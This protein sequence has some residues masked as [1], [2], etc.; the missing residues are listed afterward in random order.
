M[1]RGA[2]A[3]RSLSTKTMAAPP[4]MA[5]ETPATPAYGDTEEVSEKVSIFIPPEA[6]GGKKYEIGDTVTLTVK[7]IDQETGEIEAAT[8]DV[9]EEVEESSLDSAIEAMPED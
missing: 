1:A 9:E 2:S 8:G 7:D 4:T 5:G 3:R 6:L